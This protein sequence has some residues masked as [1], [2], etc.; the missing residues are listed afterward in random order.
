MDDSGPVKVEPPAEGEN[1]G[2]KLTYANGVEMFHGGPSG[3]TFEGTKGKIYVNRPVLE[4]TPNELAA[5]E[6]GDG[7]FHVTPSSDHRR[8]WL[9]AV[10]SRSQPIATAEIGHRTGTVCH[11]TNLGYQL[12]RP[13]EWDPSKEQFV[14]DDEANSLVN[15]PIRK[16]WTL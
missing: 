16:P 12:R 6:I 15:Q 13:L 11:L 3:C 4:T 5:K 10:R 2:L 8:N 7:E 14:D 1:S 9:D